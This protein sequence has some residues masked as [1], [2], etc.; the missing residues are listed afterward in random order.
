MSRR[1]GGILRPKMPAEMT[2]APGMMGKI[3]EAFIDNLLVLHDVD[4][5]AAGL[6]D[7]GRPEGYIWRQID[8]WSKRYRAS[9]TDDIDEL[10]RAAAWLAEVQPPESAATL[11]HND[12]KYDNLVLDPGDWSSIIGVLDWEMATIGDPLMDLGSSLGYWVEA[13]DPAEIQAL[14]LSPTNVPGN[15]T[16]EE[17]LHRYA[18]GSGREVD[19]PA[20]YYVYGLFKL[21]VIVQQIYARY[22]RGDTQDPRFANLIQAVRACGHMAGQAIDKGR[23]SA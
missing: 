7:L 17:L 9:Q 13:G 4:V 23:I 5:E 22:R 1:K 20:F 19:N 6:G 8:G 12:Y 2:P 15:P 18:L 16:R 14:R 11:I 21:A 3:A 10:E